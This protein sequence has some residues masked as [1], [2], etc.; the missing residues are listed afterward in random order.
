MKKILL[1]SLL[2]AAALSFSIG[3]SAA[4]LTQYVGLAQN[5]LDADLNVDTNVT[6]DLDLD[7]DMNADTSAEVSAES[8]TESN[9]SGVGNG[10]GSAVSIP[11]V[12]A[13]D[14]IVTRSQVEAEAEAGAEA[15]S[16]GIVGIPNTGVEISTPAAA[17]EVSSEI[18]LKAFVTGMIRED[19]KLDEMGF[20]AESVEAKY[21]ERGRLAALIP[22]SYTVGI[23]VDAE[24]EVD[25]DFPWYGFMISGKTTTSSELEELI[26]N[27]IDE[28]LTANT[29]GV[30]S[31]REQ[32]E[33]SA[34][35]HNILKNKL[36][37]ES[38]ASAEFEVQSDTSV[39]F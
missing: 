34:R 28:I 39:V 29:T 2:P 8:D 5:Y 25:V 11:A 15:D 13:M 10:Q 19:Q 26:W 7:T 38:E 36:V 20:T 21:K 16:R 35:V 23:T 17:S 6:T 3:A 12:G 37:T 32:A 22:V 9:I 31:V 4:S 1:L 33:I 18:D 24:G 30:F 14:L 27:D